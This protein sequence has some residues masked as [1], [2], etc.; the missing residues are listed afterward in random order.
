MLLVA[1]NY[2]GT[3]KEKNLGSKLLG[4]FDDFKVIKLSC[5]QD[6]KEDRLQ[7]CQ[8]EEYEDLQQ[9][10]QKFWDQSGNFLE[11][12]GPKD[13]LQRIVRQMLFF[14]EEKKF[15]K[16]FLD[17]CNGCTD[18]P[19]ACQFVM[20]HL[21]VS[22]WEQAIDWMRKAD[23]IVLNSLEDEENEDLINKIIKIRP[24]IL[25]ITKNGQE[26]LLK[27]MKD[28]L[29]VLFAGYMGKRER[30]K[31]MLQ[32]Q[33]AD[34]AISC[35]QARSMAEKLGVSTFLFGNV[36]DECGYRITNCGLSCF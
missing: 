2:L 28:G 13:K 11:L 33:C 5:S 6:Y 31:H 18:F 4:L 27:G 23:I 15:E 29:D 7:L 21:P 10:V 22:D 36:C 12:R 3:V 20:V 16:V 14:D 24:D 1:L 17:G 32:L 25:N 8:P 35:A 19:W 9:H 26:G 34:R 30:I